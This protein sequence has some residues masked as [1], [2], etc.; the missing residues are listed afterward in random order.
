[1]AKARSRGAAPVSRFDGEALGLVLFALGIFLGVTVFMEPAQPG[2]E[3]ILGQAR[4]LLVGWLGWAA[5]LLPVARA[6]AP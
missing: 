4:A 3:S 6:V 5:T 2:S 1:M